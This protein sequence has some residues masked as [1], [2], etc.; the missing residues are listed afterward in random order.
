M[1]AS[2]QPYPNLHNQGKSKAKIPGIDR[3]RELGGSIDNNNEPVTHLLLS[4]HRAF[5]A[6]DSARTVSA[7]GKR[8][9][10]IQRYR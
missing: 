7:P 1:L 6:Y 3:L 9:Q 5:S 10:T 4:K 8:I 2:D